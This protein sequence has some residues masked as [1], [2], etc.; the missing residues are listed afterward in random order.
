MAEVAAAAAGREGRVFASSPYTDWLLWSRLTLVS[1]I[2]FDARLELLSQAQLQ[3]LA[4]FM[5]ADGNWQQPAHGYRVFMLDPASDQIVERALIHVLR[6]RVIF[7]SPRV[8]VLR[9]F[10]SSRST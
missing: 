5:T 7:N 10:W 8:V 2:A 4:Q 9:R 1:R 3:Q 6:A